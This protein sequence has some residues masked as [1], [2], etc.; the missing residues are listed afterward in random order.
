MPDINILFCYARK[1]KDLFIQ[2]KNHLQPLKIEGFISE[3]SDNAI[4]PGT[5]WQQELATQ[6]VD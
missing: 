2:L 1:D 6:L 5:A 4:S 3:W